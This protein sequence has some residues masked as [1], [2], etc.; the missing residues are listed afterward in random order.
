[1]AT[2]MQGGGNRVK[3]YDPK[4]PTTFSSNIERR[5]RDQIKIA[6]EN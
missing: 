2:I 1:M 5:K 3:M 4:R 6:E